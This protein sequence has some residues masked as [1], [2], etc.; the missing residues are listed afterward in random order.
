MPF[1]SVSRSARVAAVI[2]A[3]ILAG[4]GAFGTGTA[5]GQDGKRDPANAAHRV[6]VTRQVSIERPTP[7][8]FSFIA[9][10]DVLPKVLTG[11]GPLPAVI[12]TSKHTGAW[13]TPGSARIVHLADGNTVREQLTAYSAPTSAQGQQGVL[14]RNADQQHHPSKPTLLG[15]ADERSTQCRNSGLRP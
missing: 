11:Y 1:Q 14:P 10:E 8:V 12:R 6:A 9:A 5:V 13:D 15:A 2:L 3:S 7:V 4:I